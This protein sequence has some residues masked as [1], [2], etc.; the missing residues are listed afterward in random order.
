MNRDDSKTMSKIT[1]KRDMSRSAAIRKARSRARSRA[2]GFETVTLELSR[3]VMDELRATAELTGGSVKDHAQFLVRVTASRHRRETEALRE[4]ARRLGDF[5]EEIQPY[6]HAIS[7]PGQSVE[8]KGR[9]VRFEDWKPRADK[10]REI[11][12]RLARRGWS[13][14]RIEKFC[15]SENF[16]LSEPPKV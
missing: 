2:D 1:G 5:L 8:I 15:K 7:R 6:V 16:S 9:V 11:Q 12:V 13:R 10:L 14:S 4:E 3:E